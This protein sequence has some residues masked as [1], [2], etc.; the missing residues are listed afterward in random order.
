[1]SIKSTSGAWVILSGTRPLA[2]FEHVKASLL[3]RIW[4]VWTVWTL[5]VGLVEKFAVVEMGRTA[6]RGKLWSTPSHENSQSTHT[7][8]TG[9]QRASHF[10]LESMSLYVA[11]LISVTKASMYLCTDRRHCADQSGGVYNSDSTVAR[12]L[13]QGKLPLSLGFAL[14]LGSVYS[15]KSLAPVL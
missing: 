15:H 6:G 14:R 7:A 3:W 13:W 12:D 9:L 5:E 2:N 11:M 8:W 10:S 4:S 1:M